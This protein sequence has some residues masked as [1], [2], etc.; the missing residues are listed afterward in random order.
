VNLKRGSAELG[1][2]RYDE[3]LGRLKDELDALIAMRA[4]LRSS[5]T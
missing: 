5:G 2:Y 1:A 4:E 3:I